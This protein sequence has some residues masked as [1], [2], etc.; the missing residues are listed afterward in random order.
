MNWMNLPKEYAGESSKFVVFPIEYESAM[1]YGDGASFGSHEIIKASKHL[2]YYDEQF[3]IEPFVKG[4]HLLE[5]MNL[6]N[7]KPEDMVKH[8]SERVGKVGRDKFIVTLGGDHAVTIGVVK[9][10]EKIHDDFSI[11]ML[12][13]HSDFRDSWNNSEL[14]HACVAKQISKQ[15]DVGIIGVRS[16]DV[17]ESKSVES[18][19][20]VHIIKA[21]DFNMDNLK[22]T[23]GKL[24][25]NVFIS[26]DVDVFDLSFIRN[27]GT[28]EPG[29]FQWDRVIEILKEIFNQKK[30][31][32]A[33]ITEFAPKGL[34]ENFRAEAYSL[35]KLAYKIMSLSYIQS[36][37]L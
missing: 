17:D 34:E 37:N 7:I 31:I 19:K 33:D 30:V 2:E 36:V 27:T 11:V 32:G 10:L 22:E 25:K 15:H 35:A 13:A 9:G 4:I 3:G 21:Y 23:L 29:G 20:N 24:K 18:S 28:P 26:I 1:T 14:N 6:A 16:Q 5:P 8:V 12:D